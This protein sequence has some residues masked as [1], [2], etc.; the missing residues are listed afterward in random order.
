MIPRVFGFWSI[1]HPTNLAFAGATASAP[2]TRHVLRD[3]D[4]L[5]MG[6]TEWL[7][8]PKYGSLW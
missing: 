6:Q 3:S 4:G 2:S 5:W 1:P 7:S 8:N